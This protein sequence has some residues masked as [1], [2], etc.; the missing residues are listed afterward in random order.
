MSLL[1]KAVGLFLCTACRPQ[2]L[3]LRDKVYAQRANAI[4]SAMRVNH[5]VPIANGGKSAASTRQHLLPLQQSTIYDNPA[6][7]HYLRSN[8]HI[9]GRR[10][11]ATRCQHGLLVLHAYNRLQRKSRS[12]MNM[13]CTSYSRSPLS[14]SR[15]AGQTA[16]NPILLL[17]TITTNAR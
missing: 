6:A 14:I 3:S 11:H 8:S 16:K 2:E 13:Y 10:L 15:H 7:F 4:P 12:R 17:Q 9:T 1:N 5:S